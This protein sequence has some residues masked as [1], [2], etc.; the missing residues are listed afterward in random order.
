VSGVV[1]VTIRR[2]VSGEEELVEASGLDGREQKSG[3]RNHGAKVTKKPDGRRT[4][5]T[6]RQLKVIEARAQ[7]KTLKE[8]GEAAGYSPKNAAQ[9][10]YQALAGLGHW[11]LRNFDSLHEYFA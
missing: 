9:S 1:I 11:C 7:G 8:S 3:I 6:K 10:A 4:K 5:V 2:W